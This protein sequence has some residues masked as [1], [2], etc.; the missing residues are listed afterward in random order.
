MLCDICK[1]RESIISYT[2][3]QGDKI[4]EV[5]L[6]GECAEEKLKIDF[7][8]NVNIGFQLEEFLKNIFQFTTEN[9]SEEDYK[10]CPNCGM[11]FKEYRESGIIGC[12]K[13]YDTFRDEIKNYFKSISKLPKHIGNIPENAGKNLKYKRKLDDLESELEIL[14]SLEEYESAAVIRDKIKSLKEEIYEN[15]NG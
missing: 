9:I 1:E 15:S 13:C 7:S 4:E 3:V 12:S 2:K 8:K 14:I 6:C 11:S 10:E 5:H